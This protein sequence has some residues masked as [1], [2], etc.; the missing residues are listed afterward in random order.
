MSRRTRLFKCLGGLT[1]GVLLAA[2]QTVPL[3]GMP[4]TK[5]VEHTTPAVASPP[6]VGAPV[7]WDGLG[8]GDAL[9]PMLNA[10]GKAAHKAVPPPKNASL[11]WRLRG[12]MGIEPLQGVAQERMT[13]HEAWYRQRP[14]HLRRVFE[15]ARPYLFDIVEEVQA[16]G[17]PMEVALLPAVES[18]FMPKAVSSAQADGLWQFMAPT[19]ARFELRRNLFLDERR[20][21][22]AATRAALRYLAWL[23]DRYNGDMQ[24][25][26]AAYNCGEGCIDAHIRRA[27]AKG[28]AGRFEDL[29]LNTETAQYVPRLVALSK[30]V[31]DAVDGERLEA[32][33]LPDVPNARTVRR[34]ALQRDMDKTLVARLAGVTLAELEALN[35]QHHKPLLV[36]SAGQG[37]VLPEDKAT[38]FEQA[39]LQHKGPWAS[40]TV[41]RVRRNTTVEAIARA[42]GG[43]AAA[44]RWVNKIAPGHLVVAGSTVLVPR[45]QR[46]D[47]VAEAQLQQAVLRTMPAMTVVRIKVRKGWS[48]RDVTR[49]VNAKG[50]PVVEGELRSANPKVKL[51]PG[52][53]R[54][55]VPTPGASK[56][57]VQTVPLALPGLD[58]QGV[59]H[60]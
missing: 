45:V 31:A 3:T 28:L 10:P 38:R 11:W 22:Q 4:S 26:L 47:D 20:S 27:R 60:A 34:L 7:L 1:V 56:R 51:R 40:W 29:Q 36:A 19:A 30:V 14:E 16:A 59:R 2:C 33:G 9:T 6:E 23:R 12:G 54:L 43:D 24:L 57:L 48:W 25:A 46:W 18:A 42:H 55:R 58:E 21:P 49:A 13:V 50:G 37:V 39:L 52:W 32:V 41:H 35:P 44:I 53:L 5:V 15:R 8:Q 17:L